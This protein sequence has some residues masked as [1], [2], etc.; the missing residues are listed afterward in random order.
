MH[1]CTIVLFRCLLIMFSANMY[2]YM[3]MSINNS[4]YTA[5]C[6]LAPLNFNVVPTLHVKWS[7]PVVISMSCITII[8]KKYILLYALIV[9]GRCYIL[10]MY[11][12]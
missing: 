1:I 11:M 2:M 8:L 12:H 7:S 9:Y 6:G 5:M 3:Y 4:V 10:Y